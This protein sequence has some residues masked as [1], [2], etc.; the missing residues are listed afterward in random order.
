MATASMRE[1][2]KKSSTLPQSCAW[3]WN[4]PAFCRRSAEKSQMLASLKPGLRLKLRAR[5]GP[6]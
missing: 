3:G 6:Q 4:R 2:L 1:L 5:F